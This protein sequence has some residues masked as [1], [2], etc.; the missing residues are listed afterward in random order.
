MGLL[1]AGAGAW[2]IV[3]MTMGQT[4]YPH[5]TLETTLDWI[6]NLVAFS[7]ALELGRRAK[8]RGRFLES[9]VVFAAVLSLSAIF[10]LLTSPPGRVFWLFDS[11]AGVATL[12]PFVYRNQYAAFVEAVLPVATFRAVR[13]RVRH[14]RSSP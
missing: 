11:S 10:T 9:A 2:G 13:F 1:L 4:V 8:E 14:S 3:Q 6:T 5:R 12:G 7:L